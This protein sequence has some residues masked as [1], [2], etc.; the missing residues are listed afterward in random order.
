MNSRPELVLASNTFHYA[1]TEFNCGSQIYNT[2]LLVHTRD[3]F[4]VIGQIEASFHTSLARRRNFAAQRVYR[5]S[6]GGMVN[7]SLW[8]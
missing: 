6:V 7:R 8:G 5:V 3:I 4:I 2:H 1:K